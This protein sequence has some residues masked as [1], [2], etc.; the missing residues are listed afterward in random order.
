MRRNAPVQLIEQDFYGRVILFFALPLPLTCPY[1]I[2]TSAPEIL[3]L[4]LIEPVNWE[5]ESP[6]FP[7]RFY[8][9]AEANT[10]QIIDMSC[11]QSSVG[12]IKDRGRWAL[13]ER[14]NTGHILRTTDD[15]VQ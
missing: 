5:P 9:G 15:D 6:S 14:A 10:V 13:I 8:R 2:G 3:L 11:I 1:R 12:R 4:A 7:V